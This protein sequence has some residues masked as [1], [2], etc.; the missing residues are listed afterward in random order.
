MC[1]LCYLI[2]VAENFSPANAQ[3][4]SVFGLQNIAI[5]PP[6]GAATPSSL[7]MVDVS[8]VAPDAMTPQH[9][10]LNLTG[11]GAIEI[12]LT[13]PGGAAIQVPTPWHTADV[14]IPIIHQIAR[15]QP[16]QLPPG[17]YDFYAR[18][19]VDFGTPNERQTGFEQVVNDFVVV[20]E[21]SVWLLALSAIPVIARRRR[22]AANTS[23]AF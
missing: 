12:L 21:P 9:V 2:A 17:V 18:G 22:S 20:P 4:P 11:P 19:I 13:A 1:V 8:G 23:A 10:A 3:A 15:P 7:I 6:S 14:A 16:I 5:E